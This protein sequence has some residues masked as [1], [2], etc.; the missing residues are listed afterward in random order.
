MSDAGRVLPARGFRRKAVLT[1]LAGVAVLAA[2]HA[3]ELLARG[4]WGPPAAVYGLLAA[5][6][7]F[8]GLSL[9]PGAGRL[10]LRS[11]GF[12]VRQR[13]TDR[14]YRW[15]DVGPFSVRWAGPYRFVVFD[16]YGVEAG[17][18][19]R[20]TRGA[21]IEPFGLPWRGLAALLNDWRHRHT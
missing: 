3:Q 8:I 1:G 9:L 12:T 11:D 2:P 16:V 19:R 5:C 10:E 4:I 14:S 6:A 13:F 21:M 18:R 7:V 20:V 17:G 15:E